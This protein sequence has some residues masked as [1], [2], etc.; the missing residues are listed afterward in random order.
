MQDPQAIYKLIVLYMMN[1]VDFSLTKAQISDF[2]LKKEYTNFYTLQQVFAE[3]ESSGMITSQSIHNRTNLTLTKEGR[4]TLSFFESS[5]SDAI[6]ADIDTFLTENSMTLRDETSVTGT[7]YKMST[8]DYEVQ[9]EAREK[10]I[11]FVRVS[12]SVPDEGSA[13]AV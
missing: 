5:V 12:L 10:G 6:K 8:G 2:I 9:L 11:P 4:D 3:L 7:Y 1:R 13:A